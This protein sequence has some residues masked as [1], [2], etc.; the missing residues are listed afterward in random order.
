MAHKAARADAKISGSAPPP[1]H[2]VN[3]PTAMMKN[4][5]YGEGYQY[6]HDAPDGFSGQ[7]FFPDGMARPQHYLP[8][9]RG[10]ER[11]LS[12]RVRYFEKLRKVRNSEGG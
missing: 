9:E 10:F 7:V 1:M 11:E 8:V 2:I 6:D 4:L 3:A 5:G 12:K